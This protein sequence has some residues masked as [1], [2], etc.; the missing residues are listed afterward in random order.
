MLIL[1]GIVL[2][3]VDKWFNKVSEDQEITPKKAIIIGFFQVIAMIPGVSR[4]AA[5]IIG[6]MTQK[7]SRKNAA[8]FSFFLAVP[9]MFAAAGYKLVKNYTVFTA[10]HI[11]L[12]V[13]GNVVSFIVALIAIKSFITFLTK[14][15][16]KIFGYYRIIIGLL[17]LILYLIG[18]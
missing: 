18:C 7:L 8:E 3:F 14:H 10:D 17:I 5:T 16:F 9:T 2:L 12:L 1:G 6:G 15:G 11:S 4:S 13:F